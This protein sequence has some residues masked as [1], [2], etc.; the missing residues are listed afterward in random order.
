MRLHEPLSQLHWPELLLEQRQ[1][2]AT[3]PLLGF[4]SFWLY[5]LGGGLHSV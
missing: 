4:G 2:A 1:Y 3:H 5:V